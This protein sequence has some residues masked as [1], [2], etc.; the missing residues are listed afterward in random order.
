MPEINESKLREQIS[1]NQLAPLYF[2][3]G[4]EKFLVKRDI[5]RLTKKFAAASAISSTEAVCG[6]SL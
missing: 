1:K 4:D 6:N 3:Y 2:L 5:L